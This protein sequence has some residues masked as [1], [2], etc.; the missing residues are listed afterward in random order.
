[1]LATDVIAVIAALR[2]L[3][4]QHLTVL[5]R[6]LNS[7][8]SS[9]T[10]SHGNISCFQGCFISGSSGDHKVEIYENDQQDATV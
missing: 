7:F 5:R 9:S 10:Y 4:K 1:M 2:H 6:V 8:T 3:V